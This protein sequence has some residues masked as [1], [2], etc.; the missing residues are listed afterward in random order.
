MG[1][2]EW[3]KQVGNKRIISLLVAAST[4]FFLIFCSSLLSD[5]EKTTDNS[6]VKINFSFPPGSL[7]PSISPIQNSPERQNN[8]TQ[9]TIES[10][11]GAGEETNDGHNSEQNHGASLDGNLASE[12]V[13]LMT[14]ENNLKQEKVPLVT[15][16]ATYNASS[17]PAYG[18]A[19]KTIFVNESE[20][21]IYEKDVK[22]DDVQTIISDNPTKKD[23]TKSVNEINISNSSEVSEIVEDEKTAAQCDIYSGKWVH[24]DSYPLY[25]AGECPYMSGDFNCKE[26][27]R[28]DLEFGK[29]RWQPTDC[30]LPR[31]NATDMLERLRGKR[32]MF[33]GDSINRNQWESLL[34]MLRS[35]DYNCTVE[36]FWAPFLIEQGSIN[37][38]NKTKEILRLDAIEKHGAHWK[39]VDILVFNSAHWWTH[40]NKVASRDF[41]QEGDYLHPELDPMVAFK[42]G[43]TTWAN[44][45][46]SNIDPTRT[47]VFFRGFSPMHFSSRQWNKPKGHKCNYETEPIFNESYVNPYPLRMKVADQVLGQMKF[48]VTLMNITRL[49]DFRKDAHPSV[50]TL[51]EK[52]KLTQEQRNNPDKYGDCSHWCLPGLPDIWNELLYGSLVME[53]ITSS[54]RSHSH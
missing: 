25:A 36:F 20:S 45:V 9:V 21:K 32:L 29:W 31:F 37:V 52:K 46:D 50:Y 12:D 41:Y 26:N 13:K 28:Q 1:Q 22:D 4:I 7:V 3:T 23:I 11:H 51:R 49:S 27:G 53:S 54:P 8:G 34:C 6:R 16:E 18:I 17:S 47:K 40:G 35:A 44:W 43:M 48:P 38:N 15:V 19:G 10:L 24:D 33:I 30:V 2:W 14:S 39:D 5:G 42:K